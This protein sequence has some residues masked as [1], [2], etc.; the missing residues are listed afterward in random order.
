[1]EATNVIIK[2]LSKMNEKDFTKFL[3][4]FM[5]DISVKQHIFDRQEEL[6]RKIESFSKALTPSEQNMLCT[7]NAHCLLLSIDYEIDPFDKKIL[8]A[9]NLERKSILRKI[10]EA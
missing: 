7:L 5:K 10:L 4:T 1:M 6:T 2:E 3:K 8:I 9:Y